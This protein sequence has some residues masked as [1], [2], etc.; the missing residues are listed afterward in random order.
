[1]D[2]AS[3]LTCV[4]LDGLYS[5]FLVVFFLTLKITLDINIWW[6]ISQFS[7][8]IV[9]VLQMP[10]L[11]RNLVMMKSIICPCG[12]VCILLFEHGFDQY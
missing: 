5:S 12:L 8:R 9:R 3:Q 6:S 4:P 1:M 7:P 10:I 11:S 2:G